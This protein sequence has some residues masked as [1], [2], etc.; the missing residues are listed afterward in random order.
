VHSLDGEGK[1]KLLARLARIEGQV[2]GLQRMIEND[3]YCVDVLTQVSAVRSAL[4]KVG[5]QVL[6]GH[7]KGCVRTALESDEDA[8]DDAI[9]RELLAV[10]EKFTD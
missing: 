8:G 6:D 7:V 1:K 5:L 9:I 10:I 3:R 4:K 2:R